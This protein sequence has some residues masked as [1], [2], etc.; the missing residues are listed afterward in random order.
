MKGRKW[1]LGNNNVEE[2][3]EYKNLR[4]VK[5][6]I[7]SFSSN[8]EEY[9]DKTCKNAGIL[10]S[11]NFDPYK[12]S[13]LVYIKFWRVAHKMTILDHPEQNLPQSPGHHPGGNTRNRKSMLAINGKHENLRCF[14]AWVL[15]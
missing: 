13:P 6:Y 12:V 11:V 5:N 3:Y 2:L 4:V 7:A 1:I 9:I 8:V 15:D 10:F 14:K